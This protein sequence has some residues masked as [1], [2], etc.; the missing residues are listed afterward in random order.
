MNVSNPTKVMDLVS[1]HLLRGGL[2]KQKAWIVLGISSKR[3][4]VNGTDTAIVGQMFSLGM[5][6]FS[7][8]AYAKEASALRSVILFLI[9]SSKL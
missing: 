2:Q 3:L 1:E 6:L 5:V 8:R 9:S 7:S 4:C